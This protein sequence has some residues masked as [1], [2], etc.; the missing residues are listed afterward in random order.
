MTQPRVL[1]ACPTYDGCAYALDQWADAYW[2]FT[3]ADRGVLQVDNSSDN[4]DYTHL[5]RKHGIPAIYEPH[6]FNWIWHTLE[7]SWRTILEY[8][9]DHEYDLIASIE[10]DIICPPDALGLLVERWQAAGPRAIV[11]QRYLARGIGQPHDT[12][13]RFDKTTWIDTLGC[14][15]FPTALMYETRNEWLEIFEEELYRQGRLQGYQRVRT[16]DLFD[17]HH[18]PDP[19]RGRTMTYPARPLFAGGNP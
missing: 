12:E 7:L 1:V 9:H 17:A 4:L 2:A 18:L 14:T 8:A 11:A 15:L 5:I 19:N 13:T 6:H 3:Y 10:A 16:A